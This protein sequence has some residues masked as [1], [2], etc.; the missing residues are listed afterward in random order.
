MTNPLHRVPQILSS[1]LVAVTGLFACGCGGGDNIETYKVPK[2]TETEYRILGAMYPADDP[3][4]FFKFAG[5]TEQI[6]QYEADFDKLLDSVTLPPGDAAPTFTVPE[7]WSRGP[8]RAGIV[9]ATAR[10]PDGKFEVTLTS[11]KGGVDGNLQ[12]WAIQQLGLPAF[13]PEDKA[14]AT[15]VIDAK[16]GKGLRV[17][18]RGPKNPAAARGPMMG[19]K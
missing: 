11:S 16:G 14:K 1:A 4:W 8:G 17:D 7:G 9:E 10:T 6:A 18:L 2:T 12:R 13:G 3:G 19:G 15:R 5:P